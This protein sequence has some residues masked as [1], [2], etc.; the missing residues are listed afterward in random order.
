MSSRT[1]AVVRGRTALALAAVLGAA[2]LALVPGSAAAATLRYRVT[3]IEWSSKLTYRGDDPNGAFGDVR[4][5]LTSRIAYRSARS[6]SV[7]PGGGS[8]SATG[9]S[10]I[11]DAAS[12]VDPSA[13]SE[14]RRC[15]SV[16]HSPRERTTIAL[17]PG[18]STMAVDFRLPF[19][20]EGCG[21]GG[22]PS[23]AFAKRIADSSTLR[24]RL[25]PFRG[26]LATVNGH[27][28]VTGSE[29]GIDRVLTWTAKVT[30]RRTG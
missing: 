24:F 29:D 25:A 28:R 12:W 8:V 10:R 9:R 4:G 15:S 6:L 30:L 20:L 19:A 7:P 27:G 26:S 3:G 5:T 21:P 1:R 14:R 13:P 2:A 17:D 11:G 16:R 23:A 18:S 22:T